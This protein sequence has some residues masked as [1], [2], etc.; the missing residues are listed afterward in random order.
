MRWPRNMATY[1]YMGTSDGPGAISKE[2]MQRRGIPMGVQQ[3]GIPMREQPNGIPAHLSR[4]LSHTSAPTS[5]TCATN[6]VDVLF[7]A[8]PQ[9]VSQCVCAA[10]FSRHA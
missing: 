1:G 7:C 10:E 6:V 2:R 3:R 4:A 8:R 5:T 9:H